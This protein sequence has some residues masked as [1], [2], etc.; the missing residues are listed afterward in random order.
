MDMTPVG[1]TAGWVAAER[2]IESESERP[3]FVDPLARELA[4][5]AGFRFAEQ[6]KAAG[7]A[8][9]RGGAGGADPFLVVRTKFLDDN[10]LKAVNETPL[11]QA[12]ILAAGLDARAFRLSWPRGM[13]CFEVDRD[14]VF[15]HKES[16]LARLGA[17]P[18]CDRRVVRADLAGDWV[19]AL[20][21]AGFDPAAPTAFLVEGLLAYLDEAAVNRLFGAIGAL[22]SGSSWI[23]FDVIGTQVMTSPFMTSFLKFLEELGCPFRFGVDDPAEF[24]ARHGW[25]GNIAIP[26][27]PTA[28]FD[29]WPY[30]V[31]ARAHPSIP[32]NYLIEARRSPA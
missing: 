5:E 18:T 24:L 26:G 1:S 16:V 10:M 7:R 27:E 6:M 12:V 3:L 2:A 21:Q 31:V 32:R 30:P 22:A 23:G 17:R 29:R 15:D 20:R 19:P 11:T 9:G 4:G 14:E 8:A 25:Q 28:S 13:V